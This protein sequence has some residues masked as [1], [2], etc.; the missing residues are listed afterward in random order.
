MNKYRFAFVKKNIKTCICR[1][2]DKYC[3]LL[4]R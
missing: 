1:K 2:C 3:R 4:A